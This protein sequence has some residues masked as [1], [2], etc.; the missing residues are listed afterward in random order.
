KML[1]ATNGDELFQKAE[2]NGV[3]LQYEASV[4][5][6]IPIINGIE[7]SLTANKIKELYG[8][9]NGTTNYILTKMQLDKMDFDTA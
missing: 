1:L 2:S 5:G 9:V 4:A 7:E 8:I 6:G 3:M